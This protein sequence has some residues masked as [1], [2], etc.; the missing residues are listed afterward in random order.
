MIPFNREYVNLLN[1]KEGLEKVLL[2]TERQ[3]EDL[4]KT[5]DSEK[6]A[7]IRLSAAIEKQKSILLLGMG[8][9]HFLNHMLA[10]QLRKLGYRAVAIPASEY[11]YDSFD[12]GESVVI[13]T[14]QS[15]ESVETVKCMEKLNGRELFCV[16]LERK[17]TLANNCHAIVAAGGGEKAFAGTRSVTLTLGIFSLLAENLGMEPDST[18]KAVLEKTEDNDKLQEAINS[19]SHKKNLIVTGRGIYYGLSELFRLGCEELSGIPAI[20][21]EAG[22]LRHGPLELLAVDTTL[23]VFRQ[24]GIPSQLSLSLEEAT[25]KSGADLIVFDGSGSKAL[26]GAVTIPFPAGDSLA[27]S[28]AIL[29]SLQAFMISYACKRNP[30]AGTPFYSVKVTT[31][32]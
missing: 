3:I 26:K 17:S 4:I 21:Y 20:C 28:L 31:T 19:V 13:L 9:S 11:Y 25:Q 2:E 32:E 10:I 15:G 7:I 5:A 18:L 27:S 6:K 1:K 23:I 12:P 30:Q 8:A 24:F 16:T 29:P 14:S 22:Q